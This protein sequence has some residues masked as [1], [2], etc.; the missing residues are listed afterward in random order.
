MKIRTIILLAAVGL[1]PMGLNAQ[2][3]QQPASWTLKQC[4]DYAITHNVGVQQSAVSARQQEVTVNTSKWARLPEVSGSAGQNWSWGRTASPQDNSYISSN[5]SNSS[6]SVGASIPLFTG[7]KIPNQYKLSQIQLKAA[8]ADLQKAKEDLSINVASSYLQA[9]LNKELLKVAEEQITLSKEQLDRLVKME[10]V[11]K[12]SPA[13]VAEARAT[14]ESNKLSAVQSDNTYKLSILDLTQLLELPTPDGFEIAQPDLQLLISKL[15]PP[16]ELYQTAMAQKSSIL[17]AQ[18]RLEGSD[19]SIKIARSGYM[20]TVSMN[21]GL[22]TSYYTM[23]GATVSSFSSQMKNNLNK[24]IGMSLSVPIFDRFTTRNN[25]RTA[26]LQQLNYSLQLENTKKVFYK[27]IQQAWY[28]A[29]AA[30]NKYK[31]SQSAL[32]AAKESF[33]LM[34]AKYENGK[35]TAVEYNESQQKLRN[36]ESTL[37]QAKYDYIF[38]SKILDFYKGE[39]IK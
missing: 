36:A 16:D 39:Q 2:T 6:F 3:E 12:A 23:S 27:E 38:R 34:R 13:Q 37:L 4:I 33:L 5:S 26:K 22:G 11:G 10:E 14:V 18:Y 7:F 28:S 19:L 31:S 30:E 25:I 32:D 8:L 9:L 21:L 24:Y 15:T 17:A 35:A 29:V 20:P 1:L